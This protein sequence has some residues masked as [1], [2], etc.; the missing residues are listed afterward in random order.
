MTEQTALPI[1]YSFRRCPYAMRARLALAQAG[2]TVELREILLRDKPAAMLALSPK[3]TVPV[4]QTAEGRV[5][6]ESLEVMHWALQQ[7]DPDAWLAAEPELAAALI[8]ENDNGF[9]Q[10]LDHYKYF[11]RFPEHPREHYRAQGE[12]FLQKLEDNLAKYT[13][14]ALTG[15]S[16]ALADMAIFPFVRQFSG[17]DPKWF[18]D[19]PYPLLKAWLNDL[20]D[21]ALFA[22]V[23]KKYPPWQPGDATTKIT[24]ASAA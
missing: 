4:V 12:L 9:K 22:S 13:G 10:A 8:E 11:T 20:L 15:P 7:H 6:D 23:M 2:I 14:A 1:L 18:A 17:A 21:S 24:W 19:A 16:Y 3:G 5:I